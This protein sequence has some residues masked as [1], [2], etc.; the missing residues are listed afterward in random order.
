MISCSKRS[1]QWTFQNVSYGPDKN[2][3]FNIIIPKKRNNVHAIV[4]IH[5]GFYYSGNK[6]WYPQ[7][8]TD[9]SKNNIFATIDYR[10][11]S[12]GDI[13]NNTNMHDIISDVNDA[14]I[15][16]IDV[17]NENGV[18]IKDF[19][20]VGHSAGAHIGLLYGYKYFKENNNRQI[21]ISACISLSGP[22]DYTDDLGW[23]SM[24]YHGDSLQKRLLRLSQIGTKLT[25]RNIELIQSNW[26]EQDN[27][28]E[29][30]AYIEDISP[31]K[32]VNNTDKL[33]STLLVHGMNDS[34]VPYSNSSRLN[35]ALDNTSIPHKL[36]TPTGTG[37]NHMLGGESNMTNSVEP[38]TYR[39]QP[40]VNEA[41]A[42]MKE[43]L[44]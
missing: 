1:V 16:I 25:S 26:T 8:L 14:L 39:N 24:T 32:Y 21:N 15:K 31:I 7:F 29:F 20:L 27:Y 4:Y 13:N 5:G 22:N 40:W 38:I 35:S 37:D 18:S 12:F 42:W 44:K 36:I 23:S 11:V 9:Y 28:D 34:I 17:A 10:L 3:T 19:I 6:L 2:Q 33:P 43:Y 41:R 30:K